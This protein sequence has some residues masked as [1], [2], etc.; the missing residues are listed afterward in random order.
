M[1]ILWKN[2]DKKYFPERGQEQS[3]PSVFPSNKDKKCFL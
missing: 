3:V 1:E 2:N